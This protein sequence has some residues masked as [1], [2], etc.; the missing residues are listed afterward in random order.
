MGERR[1]RLPLSTIRDVFPKRRLSAWFRRL[2]STRLRMMLTRTVSRLRM[3][4]RTTVTLSR[5][6]SLPHRLKERSQLMTRPSLRELSM[7]LFSGLTPIFL[8]RRKNSRRSR[9]HLRLLL[10]QSF[11]QWEELELLQEVCQTWEELHQVGA[12]PADDPADGPTI[13]EI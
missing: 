2:R 7:R 4:L 10:C 9:R 3:D 13:E 1:T 8:Q 12:P 5:L 11:R 6:P